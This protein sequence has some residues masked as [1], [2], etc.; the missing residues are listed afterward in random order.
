M[1]NSKNAIILLVILVLIAVAVSGCTSKSNSTVN[2]SSTK[3]AFSNN[4]TTWFHFDAVIENMTLKNGTVQNYYV[5]G[6]IKPNGNV[7]MDLSSLAGYGNEP[8]P[9]GTTVRVLAWKGLFNQTLAS[10]SSD[11]NLVMQGWSKNLQP[12]NDDLKYNVTV[13]NLPVNQLPANITDNT[14]IINNDPATITG[15]GS[16]TEP[17]FEEEIFTVDG[18][19]KVTM[20]FVTPATLCNILAT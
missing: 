7:T 3:L 8:L 20:V 17:V 2:Q 10:N 4:G 5:D 18:N 16:S 12:Q 14:I 9:A 1:K 13:L 6:Y 19:G 15:N 11:M